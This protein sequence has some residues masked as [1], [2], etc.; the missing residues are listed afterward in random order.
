[1]LGEELTEARQGLTQLIESLRSEVTFDLDDKGC[2][3]LGVGIGE[4]VEF[5]GLSLFSDLDPG[6]DDLHTELFGED[7]GHRRQGESFGKATELFSESADL[8]SQLAELFV[9]FLE[10]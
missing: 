5:E 4:D 2:V 1:M 7:F 8:L 10:L 6:S 9:G 3:L